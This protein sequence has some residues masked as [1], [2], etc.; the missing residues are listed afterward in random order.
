MLLRATIILVLHAAA[1]H[2]SRY[3]RGTTDEELLIGWKGETFNA[4]RNRVMTQ[5]E[6][7]N[8]ED[9]ERGTWV[10]QVSWEPRAYVLHNFM[11][12]AECDE[13]VR[14]AKPRL[15]RS[16]VIDEVT[17]APKE[18]DI[19]T[20]HDTFLLRH[21]KKVIADVEER[22]ARFTMLP[23]SH[24]EDLLILRYQHGEKYDAHQDVADTSSNSGRLLS[25]EG[26]HRAATVLMYLSDVEEG[27]E[28]AFVT[29]KNWIDPETAKL[30]GPWSPCADGKV[31][32]KPRKGEALLFWNLKPNGKI[33]HRSTHAAF[34]G[35]ALLLPAFLLHTGDEC[36]C[37]ARF[38]LSR[39]AAT[40]AASRSKHCTARPRGAW[41]PAGD[42]PAALCTARPRG[43][44]CPAGDPPAALCTKR[45]PC[46]TTP[47]PTPCFQIATPGP[48]I[49]PGM[50]GPR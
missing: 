11:T 29:S 42:R 49:I 15:A 44:W 50:V 18:D 20:S 36:V 8:K 22:L 46:W 1:A 12:A 2:A 10:E 3:L 45:R 47:V 23:W 24:G 9:R 6:K 5:A 30:N 7:L 38:L 14:I 33:D 16:G 32:V 17:G 21:S 13:L 35:P 4:D 27:G 37:R 31:A 34:I 28:T 26:G 39:K 41:C 19:R 43:A 25:A 40:N 48:V